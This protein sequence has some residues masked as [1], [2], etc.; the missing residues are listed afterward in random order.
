[1]IPQTLLPQLSAAE[2]A[3]FLQHK[4]AVYTDAWDLAEALRAGAPQVQVLDVRAP[5]RY[6]QGHIPGAVNFPH[7]TMT[8][9]TLA[10]LDPDKCYITYCDGIGCNGSTKGALKLAQA[11]LS[12]RELLGGLDFWLRDQHPQLSGDLPGEWPVTGTGEGCGC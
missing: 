6:R 10:A 1:M 8:A 11:G 3:T 7:R 2:T 4:L 9:E 12:V 5:E